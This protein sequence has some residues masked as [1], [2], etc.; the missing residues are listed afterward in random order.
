MD[1]YAQ[2]EPILVKDSVRC[3]L[4][5]F[6]NCAGTGMSWNLTVSAQALTFIV[7]FN[8]LRCAKVV[9]EGKAPDL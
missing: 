2:L 8:A 3:F 4:R 6:K 5:L 9:L 7:S 1:K